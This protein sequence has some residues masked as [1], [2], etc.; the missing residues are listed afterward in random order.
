MASKQ[1]RF[2]KYLYR[3]GSDAILK[4]ITGTVCPC[5]TSRSSS[6]PAYS[7]EWHRLNPTAIDCNGVGKITTTTKSISIKAVF[8]IGIQSATAF[9]N[10]RDKSPI[11]EI[12]DYDL[13]MFGQCISDGSFLDIS[14]Y[15]EQDD[16]IIYNSS[17]YVIR[18]IYDIEYNGMIG[19]I[20][21]LKKKI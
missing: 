4:S 9:L 18:N 1:E 16:Y 15:T 17:N 14:S 3:S 8:S 6:Y 12:P 2:C 13:L 7:A 20:S 19:Q 5:M 11:G 21:L 10:S